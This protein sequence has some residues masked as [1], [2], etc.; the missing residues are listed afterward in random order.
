MIP[1][2]RQ[3]IDRLVPRF[4]YGVIL[5]GTGGVQRGVD[6]QFYRLVPTDVMQIGVGLGIRDYSAA[7]V[8]GATSA[9]RTG[10]DTLLA[11]GADSIMLSGVPVSAGLGRRRVVE[12]IDEVPR[13]TG[14]PFQATLEAVV[15]AFAF[16]G[17][18]RIAM[19]SR[20]PADT[21]SAIVAYLH[22]AG[23]DVLATTSRDI[24]LAQARQL[25][26]HDGLQLA[27]DLGRE[28][29]AASPA[30]E[31]IFMP[32]GATLSLH[33]IP[34][35]EAEFHV[36]ALINL[37]AE[38]WSALIRP[39]IIPPVT[40]WGCLLADGATPPHRSAANGRRRGNAN[41]S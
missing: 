7:G 27:L 40:G 28:A 6:Y 12:L 21:N 3:W 18:S 29:M 30:A 16:L 32:G 20:F 11:E 23:I 19:A 10:V 31:A 24:S 1:E 17:V 39:G 26:M 13:R 14:I 38:I 25:S 4:R 34:A 9:L 37:S 22:E 2:D 41:G 35:L 33:A 5:P 15:G 8:Q 36:P